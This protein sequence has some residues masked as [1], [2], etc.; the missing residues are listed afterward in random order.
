[1]DIRNQ[2]PCFYNDYNRNPQ[3]ALYPSSNS[4]EQ[5][6]LSIITPIVNHG[7]REAEHLGYQHALLEAVVIGYLLEKGYNYDSAWKTIESW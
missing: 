5:H 6:T 4:I 7:L 1:M 2:Q 3:Q